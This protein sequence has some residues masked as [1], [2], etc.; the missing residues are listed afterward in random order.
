MSP[1]DPRHGRSAGY[2]AGCRGQ[3]CWKAKQ[4]YDKRRRWEALQGQPR[5]VSTVG[6]IRRIQALQ[7]LGWSVPVI[8]ER[9]GINHRQ[10]YGL[11][12]YPTCYM[13]THRTIAEVYE[14]LADR[15]PPETTKSERISA[16]RARRHAQRQGWA[17]PDRWL[18]I[19]DPNEQPDPGYRP[20]L[21]RPADETALEVD[22]LLGLGVSIHQIARQL[23]VTV[24]AIEKAASRAEVSAA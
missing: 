16:T 5:K 21:H 13:R 20:V 24:G 2:I 23:G 3:C 14:Q 17:A 15:L 18:D 11:D 6:A 4:R 19:D 10:L 22:H 7:V 1:D 8:A 12:R 9:C